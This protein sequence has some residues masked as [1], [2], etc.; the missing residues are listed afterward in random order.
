MNWYDLIF[1]NV[2]KRYYKEGNYKNDIPLLTASIIVGVSFSF[3]ILSGFLLVYYFIVGQDV[4]MLSKSPIIIFGFTFNLANYL[5]F[6][7][8]DRY[9]IVYSH[10]KSSERNDR[11]QEVLSWLF[12]ILGFASGPLV[13]LFIRL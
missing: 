12:I 7:N 11:Q 10:F 5:W 3:Y 1:Y 8:K 9:L 2:F 4:P 6:K 13:A